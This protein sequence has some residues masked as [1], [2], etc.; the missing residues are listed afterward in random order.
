MLLEIKHRPSIYDR[1][2][3]QP[4]V[5]MCVV[6]V[7]ACVCGGQRATF[8][9][10]VL[11]V[12]RQGLCFCPCSPLALELLADSSVSLCHLA[13]GLLG[14]QLSATTSGFLCGYQGSNSGLSGLLEG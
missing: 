12:L 7:G 3:I 4:M 13:V 1:A 9:G 10:S 11:S 14:L 5:C 8:Q 6:G 2:T